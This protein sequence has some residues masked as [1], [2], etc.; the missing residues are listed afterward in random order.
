M[1]TFNPILKF[2]KRK[3]KSISRIL[4]NYAIINEQITINQKHF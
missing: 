4:Y 3:N 1:G 2:L